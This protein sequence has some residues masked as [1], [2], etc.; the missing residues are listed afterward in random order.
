MNYLT[1]TTLAPDYTQKIFTPGD[2]K[3]LVNRTAAKVRFLQK[4]LGVNTLVGCGNSGVPLVSA[5][6]FKLTLPFFAVRKRVDGHSATRANGYLL[7]KGCRY[8]IIDDLIST[9][10]TMRRIVKNVRLEVD[11]DGAHKL[12]MPVGILLYH[13]TFWGDDDGYFHVPGYK[14]LPL[15]YL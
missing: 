14:R 5:V 7:A 3:T 4:K 11:E 9:G 10:A 15:F 2:F 12:P 13:E 8:L 1:G 6:S